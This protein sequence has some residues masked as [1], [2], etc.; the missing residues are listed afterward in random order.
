[1]KAGKQIFHV[2]YLFD[3]NSRLLKNCRVFIEAGQIARIIE[4]EDTSQE[5]NIFRDT[6]SETPV[7]TE[8]NGFI[9]PG[10][11]NS[12]HHTYSALARG[13]PITG[14]LS[15][16]PEILKNVW[17]KLDRVLDKEAVRLSAAVTAV[18][19]IRHG[20]TTVIDHHSSP[21]T[22]SGSL[23]I[24]ASVFKELSMTGVLSFETSDRNGKKVFEKSVEENL[25][26][27]SA[28]KSSKT[29]RGMFGLHAG[30]TLCDES[31]KSIAKQKPVDLPIHVH[32][33]ED[34]C[35]VRDAKA[36]GYDG[37]LE[38]LDEFGLLAANSLAVH[39]VH[40]LAKEYNLIETC[41]IKLVHNPQS[42]CNNCVGYGD[43]DQIPAGT[44]LLGTDGM[45]SDMFSSAQ[46]S[47]L[48][49]QA[50]SS[51]E[52]HAFDI[53]K[54]MLF[55]NPSSYLSGIFGRS[56]G[57]IV[58]GEPADFA[59]YDYASPT[60]VNSDNL[61]GHFIYGLPHSSSA[62]WV[63]ANGNLIME[64]GKITAIDEDTI[65]TSAKEKAES[66]WN[67]YRK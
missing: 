22:V 59:V 65:L 27:A 8:N 32:V 42:N 12:H 56:I 36:K 16:F 15:S 41:G 9:M 4:D 14:S 50:L 47:Y 46:F 18:D 28:H 62:K 34:A 25:T 17:W 26:F 45:N 37:S 31:L 38:R 5:S 6:F 2:K 23:D 57:K 61:M 52:Q 54:S 51:R 33:A 43:L 3:G 53:I 21:N 48:L 10:L 58:E 44:L 40:L 1:M 64:D 11:I 13:M 66:V 7:H 49:Y 67:E 30:F 20:C 60:P 24:I 19:C 39:G 63:Y 55:N 29:I 35:D